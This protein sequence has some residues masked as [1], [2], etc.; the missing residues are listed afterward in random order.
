MRAS[1]LCRSAGL[2]SLEVTQAL[3]AALIEID[4]AVGEIEERTDALDV[5]ADIV[6]QPRVAPRAGADAGRLQVGVIGGDVGD[7]Q[8]AAEFALDCRIRKPRHPSGRGRRAARS[9]EKRGR[10]A[11][12]RPRSDCWRDRRAGVRGRL[13]ADPGVDVVGDD[14]VL[15]AAEIADARTRRQSRQRPQH[16]Q[17]PQAPRHIGQRVQRR[18]TRRRPLLS[19]GGLSPGSAVGRDADR[20]VAR[21]A[22]PAE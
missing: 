5:V 21:C 20:R 18:L 10:A 22:R 1:A 17:R 7:P 6:D 3:F 4:D 8:V 16:G 2:R 9:A 13:L 19:A 11:C 15:Q 12:A 14:G